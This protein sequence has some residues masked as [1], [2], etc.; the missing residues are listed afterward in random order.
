MNLWTNDA[1]TVARAV[2]KYCPAAVQSAIA[3]ADEI[4]VHNFIFTDHWEMERTSQPVVFDGKVDW[5]TAP[6][7]DPEWVYALNRHTIFL[8]LAKAWRYTQSQKYLDAFIGLCGDWLKRVPHTKETETTAWRALEAGIR[9]EYWLR[10]LELFG[11]AVPA[12]LCRRMDESLQEHGIYLA[13]T[14]GAFHALSNWGAIQDHGLFLI[15]TRLHRPEWQ[16][17]ALERL[18]KNLHCAVLP[19][20]V[21]WEQS[22]MYHCEV[23]HAAADTLL[24]ARRCGVPV[25][26][27]LEQKVHALCTALSF[28]VAPNRHILPQSDSDDIDAGDL[29]ALGALLFD[30][31]ALAAAA[32]GPICEETLWDFG[33][34]GIARLNEMPAARPDYPSAAMAASGNPVLRTGWKETDTYLHMH[35]GPIGGGHGHAD[36][37]HLD[38]WHGGEAVLTDAGR[39]TYVDGEMRQRLKS[40]AAHNT[41]RLDGRDFTQYIDTWGWQSHAQPLPQAHCFTP[42]ADFVSG[43]HL[44]YLAQGVVVTRRVVL[45]R[46]DLV[47][48]VDTLCMADDSAHT[49]EQ[50]FHFGSGTLTVED[51]SARW[52]GE[53]TCAE[54]RWFGGEAT[55]YDAPLSTVYNTL[56]QAPALCLTTQTHGTT[57]LPFVLSLGG[58]CKAEFLSVTTAYG[59][60]LSADTAQALHI[61]RKGREYTLIFVHKSGPHDVALLC[62]GGH[63]GRGN[64]ILFTPQS[65]D[66]LCL[67]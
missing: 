18:A 50:Y 41:L 28:W 4:C 21:H 44:G 7:G 61:V 36:L 25:P 31:A 46:P 33:V 20:G 66:G 49:A 45:L 55:G 64:V 48:G 43:G 15:G 34:Q 39:Y 1:E 62:A 16:Q 23:F 60:E 53:N 37:L 8:N 5:Q 26:P 9:P 14:Y 12:E 65:P 24:V 57:A 67:N 11:E 19:D 42:Q 6:A 29:L 3:R 40:P 58:S 17:L 32:Q 38:V 47:V 27:E 2:Q 30:D 63:T 35:T 13:K 54:L 59:Q 56:T 22:P 10:A 51:S 52:Q